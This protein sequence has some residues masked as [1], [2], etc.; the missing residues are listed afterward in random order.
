[1]EKDIYARATGTANQSG[2]EVPAAQH[3]SPVAESMQAL[4]VSI[5]SLDAH[6]R[7]L[8]SRLE[9]VLGDSKPRACATENEVAVEGCKLCDIIDTRTRQI[10]GISAVVI[11][12]LDRLKL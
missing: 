9:F 11:D 5:E 6:V 1:V 4:Y 12:A 2:R 8:V 3:Q 10:R 7:D